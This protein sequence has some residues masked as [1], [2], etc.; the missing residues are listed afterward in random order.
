MHYACSNSQCSYEVTTNLKAKSDITKTQA[1]YNLQF[2]GSKSHH[3]CS[4]AFYVWNRGVYGEYIH[5]P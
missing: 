4:S 3:K 5:N 2:V 1:I